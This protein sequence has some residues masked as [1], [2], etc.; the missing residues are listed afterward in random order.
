MR[1]LT[2]YFFGQHYQYFCIDPV[3]ILLHFAEQAAGHHKCPE[4][5]W[6]NI[7]ISQKSLLDIT[8]VSKKSCDKTSTFRWAGA[9]TSQMS[10]NHATKRPH[11]TDNRLDIANV[12]KKSCDKT[13]TFPWACGRTSQMYKNHAT[14]RPFRRKA[15]WTSWTC[16]EKSCDKTSTCRL[17]AGR[18]SQMGPKILWQTV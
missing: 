3:T 7:Y 15:G 6:Q 13:S 8:N 1:F 2:V 12:P 14:K 17:T 18:T 9:R 4:I 11:F 5:M 16:W 10:K